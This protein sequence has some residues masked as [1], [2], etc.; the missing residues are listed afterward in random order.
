[1]AGRTTARLRAAST[2]APPLAR[3][4]QASRSAIPWSQVGPGWMLAIWGPAPIPAPG[5]QP[6]A[7]SLTQDNETTT[8]FLVNPIGGRYVVT[9]F[10]PPANRQV[11]DWSP[12]RRRALLEHFGTSPGVDQLD[13]TTGVVRAVS[14]EPSLARASY[15]RPA[16]RAVLVGREVPATGGSLRPA[17]VRLGLDGAQQQSYPMDFPTVGQYGGSDIS[18]PDGTQLVLGTSK[19]MAVLGN[20]GT[21]IRELTVGGAN[22]SPVRWWSAGVVLA[23]CLSADSTYP[24][25]WLVPLSGAAPTTLTAPSAAAGDLGD[26]DAW[27]IPSGTFAQSLGGCGSEYVSRVGADGATTRVEVPGVDPTKTIVV[28]GSHDDQLVLQASPACG[29][30]QSLLWFSP[31]ADTTTVVLGP[32]L[33]GGAVL[34]GLLSPDPAA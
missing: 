16:G 21:I 30:G 28:L 29:G 3:G 20:G 19:G 13:L 6:P 5:E 10:A 17:L 15:T 25:L 27:R 1:M 32:P 8:L 22:C 2:T 18:T 34:G 11:V 4:A 33:N 7:G 24:R 26:I 31:S 9:T 14:V 12:D 23:S